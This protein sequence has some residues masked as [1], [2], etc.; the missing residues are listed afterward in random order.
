MKPADRVTIALIRDEAAGWLVAR[1]TGD[2][3]LPDVVD[4]I[5][6]A[7]SDPESRSR[8]LLFDARGATTPMTLAE[9]DE[10]VAAV[11]GV[12]ATEGMRGHVAVVADD[13]RFYGWLLA[14]EAKCAI[15]GVRVIRVFRQRA[16]AEQWLSIMAPARNFSSF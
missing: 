2:V 13:D 5:R 3:T 9:V 1:A 11:R 14:Y 10:A 16:D 12:V 4:F 7:R 8:P 6:T 15:A